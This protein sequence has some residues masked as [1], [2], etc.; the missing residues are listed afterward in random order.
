MRS[1]VV[2][3]RANPH[4]KQLRAA[5]AGNPRLSGG[6]VA[7]EGEHL[8]LEALRS[9]LAIDQ[10]FLASDSALPKGVPPSIAVLELDRESCALQSTHS[11]PRESPHWSAHPSGR[12]PTSAGWTNRLFCS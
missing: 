6:L 3:S 8:L 9:G 1:A 10:V 12:S 4:L 5:F 2:T 7:I 11:R